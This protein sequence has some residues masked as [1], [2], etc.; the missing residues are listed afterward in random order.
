MYE[1]RSFPPGEI[2]FLIRRAPV[3]CEAWREVLIYL[4]PALRRERGQRGEVRNGIYAAVQEIDGLTGADGFSGCLQKNVVVSL[5]RMITRYAKGKEGR[6]HDPH[7]SHRRMAIAPPGQN[8]L[9]SAHGQHL[10]TMPVWHQ[11]RRNPTPRSILME[12]ILPQSSLW[13]SMGHQQVVD[14]FLAQLSKF[15]LVRFNLLG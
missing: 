6:H 2:V 11:M 1:T 3:G 8:K 15:R 7:L 9:T 5:A 12:I 10:R 4:V 14:L 13:V